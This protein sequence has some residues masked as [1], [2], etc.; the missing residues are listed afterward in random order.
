MAQPGRLVFAHTTYP[1][2]ITSNHQRTATFYAVAQ[3]WCG[4]TDWN[5]SHE[6]ATRHQGE[7]W[8]CENYHCHTLAFG[9]NRIHHSF[10]LVVRGGLGRPN[11]LIK[12]VQMNWKMSEINNTKFSTKFKAAWFFYMAIFNLNFRNFSS[13]SRGELSTI[14]C[15]S[16]ECAIR[17]S[18]IFSINAPKCS[19]EIWVIK[20]NKVH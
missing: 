12:Q 15:H 6:S 16:S 11:P 3:R 9:N 8:C 13:S 18:V 20:H 7:C 2:W 17:I 19:I 4:C 5:N 1:R 10:Y 14:L